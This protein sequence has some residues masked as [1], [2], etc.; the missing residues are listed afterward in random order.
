MDAAPRTGAKGA[1]RNATHVLPMS[2]R[3]A[4]FRLADRAAA[5]VDAPRL[6]AARPDVE[7]AL[8]RPREDTALRAVYDRYVAE[9]SSWEWAVSWPTARALDALCEALR[10]RHVLDLGSGLSTY[11]VCDWARR[12]GVDVDV[13]SVDDSPEWL[14]KTR[15]FLDGEGLQA[16]LIDVGELPGLPDATFDLAF[17]D[18]GRTE[19]R[20]RVVDTL[21]RVMAPRSVV[22]LDDM[23]VRGYRKEVKAKLDAAGWPLY[24]LRSQ[25]IDAKGRFAMLTGPA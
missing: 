8:A 11:V 19:E 20:A 25:T 22:V 1:L 6:R 17:D 21:V 12:S 2:V 18:I 7:A 13:V 4:P 16:R 5:T 10:P 15:A 23:N 3:R 24:S 9:V 14:A